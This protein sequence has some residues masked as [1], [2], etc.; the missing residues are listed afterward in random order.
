MEILDVHVILIR[1][2]HN[3]GNGS[4]FTD[5]FRDKPGVFNNDSDNKR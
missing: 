5:Y 1:I 2:M 3:K 4:L